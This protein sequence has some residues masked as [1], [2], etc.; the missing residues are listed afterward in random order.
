MAESFHFKYLKPLHFNPCRQSDVAGILLDVHEILSAAKKPTEFQEA[1]LKLVRCPWSNELLDLSEQIFLKLVTWQ[2][3]FLEENSDTAFPLNNHLRESIEEFLA[4]WQKLGAVYSHWLQGESQQRKKPQAFLLLRLFETLYRTLS[5][6][7]F[8]HWQLPENIWRD[9]HSVYRL[10]GERDI[11]SL[12]T[13]LPGLRHGKR[14]A[15]EKRYKQSLL[16]GLA[17]P[18]ALLPR[19]IRLLEALMEKWAPLLVL[20]STVGMGWRIHF[21]E[22]VPAVWADD[23]SSLRINF[24]SLVKLLKE[25]RAFASKVG[26]FEYWEQE[27]NETL[28]LDLLDQ[29]VQSWLGAEPEIEQPPERCH[30]VAGFKP[31]F[32][33]LAQEEKPSIWMAMG[34]GEW[35]ECHVTLGSLQIGDLVGIITN[36]LLDHLAV[37]AQLKQT[38][39]DLDSVLLKLQP[40]LHEVTPVGVQP[41]VTIQ[42]LQTYQRGLLGKIE[43]RDVLLLQQQPVEAG[44]MIR[45]LR[46]DMAYPVKLEEKANPARGV[47]QFTCRIGVNEHPSQ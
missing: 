5:L 34:Q 26:R 20:E 35:L 41:L 42:K 1:V 21:N 11:I 22:D 12:S 3:D 43:G 25:H 15:L 29:L 19:E 24:S 13:K 27:S 36:D 6:R 23:D 37:V 10:A 39:T 33:Y 17:E 14:T 4:V 46:E 47:L 40:L 38:E 7:A 28:S 31:V 45:V 44:T 32:Q 18:F 8:F 30:L 16:L 9:I 2:Q